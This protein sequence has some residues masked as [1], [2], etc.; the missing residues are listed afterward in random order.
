MQTEI[1]IAII[2]AG[3]A[4]LAAAI[5][6]AE[7]RPNLRI[8]LLDG[9][10]TIGSKILVSGGGRCNVT[11]A[12]VHPS[13]FH[14]PK[15]L[16]A[17]ILRR[18]DAQATV[19][20]FESFGV[21]LKQE[22][23]GKLFPISNKAR[24]VLDALLRRCN[25]LDIRI[26]TKH[27][28][29]SI[30]HT[31][32][33]FRIEFEQ[34]QITAQRVIM[35]TGGQSLPKSGSDGKGWAMAKRMG[36]SITPTYPALVPLVLA[37][38]FFHAGLSG[39]SH[40]VRVTTRVNRKVV[41]RR[42]GSLLWTHFGISG[43]VVLDASRFWVMAKGQGQEVTVFIS[44]FPDQTIDEVDRWLDQASRQPGRKSVG[45]LL[46]QRLPARLAE[47]LCHLIDQGEKDPFRKNIEKTGSQNLA[48]L[49]LNQ[50]PQVKRK[51]LVN[52]LTDLPVP[53]IAHRGWNFA[54]VTAGGI[55]LDEI[56]PQTM[57]S[58][59]VS[60]LYLIGEMLD[61]DGRIGGFNFQ[62]A[63]S[64]GFIAGRSAARGAIG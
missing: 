4:G 57:M 31:D 6:A 40:E 5:F 8:V 16:V 64:T 33:G 35:A 36:H 52:V 21:D 63:W 10:R 11:N 19:R 48:N 9:A 17:R 60:G 61:C 3:A 32:V 45:T 51:T 39:I 47:V 56:N 22:T 41:D 1:D 30:A 7:N 62:W 26:L 24:T 46:A 12:I 42:V 28:V 59:N 38:T 58:R 27:R 18:L 34:G 29:Q 2:G 15:R 50:L 14:A 53:V 20:W 49:P 55:P 44:C 25:E 54:E 23:T 37:D 43:P 13:D